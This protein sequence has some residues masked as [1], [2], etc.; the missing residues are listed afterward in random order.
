MRSLR[1]RRQT[2][3][4]FQ[5]RLH[6]HD[7]STQRFDF[8]ACP[9]RFPKPFFLGCVVSLHQGDIIQ[10]PP[11]PFRSA[12][13]PIGKVGKSPGLLFSQT[14][15]VECHHGQGHRHQRRHNRQPRSRQFPSACRQVTTPCPSKPR[16]QPATTI[17]ELARL[18]QRESTHR[19][20]RDENS[21]RHHLRADCAPNS[22]WVKKRARDQSHRPPTI[23]RVPTS[24]PATHRTPPLCPTDQS[25]HQALQLDSRYSPFKICC[26]AKTAP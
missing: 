1:R 8:P 7:R 26:N 22:A 16:Q 24:Q 5:L 18:Y 17:A 6:A 19:R 14:L 3:V 10:H 21:P 9:H 11:Q 2:T 23:L 25:V 15:Q 12:V 4:R 13:H 20:V